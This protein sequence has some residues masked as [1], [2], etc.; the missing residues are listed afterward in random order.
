MKSD[1]EKI[2]IIKKIHNERV[3]PEN[4]IFLNPNKT[5]KMEKEFSEKIGTAC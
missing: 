4:N 3:F 2:I 1:D 5:V